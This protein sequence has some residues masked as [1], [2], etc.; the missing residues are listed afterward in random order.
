MARHYPFS[1][2]QDANVLVFPNL[3]SANS[4]VQAAATAWAAP[5]PSA[6]SWWA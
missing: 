4:V 3:A 1:K 5:K 6:R 2:V